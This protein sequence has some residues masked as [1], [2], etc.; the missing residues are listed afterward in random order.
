M[1]LVGVG[2]CGVV[3]GIDKKEHKLKH[4]S[5]HQVNPGQYDKCLINLL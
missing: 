4:M 5:R 1:E 3:G 2:A